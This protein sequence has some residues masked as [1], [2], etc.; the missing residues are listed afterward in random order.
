VDTSNLF[1]DPSEPT[2]VT[3]AISTAAERSFLTYRGANVRFP[4]LVRS[5]A[6]E[7]RH[8]HLACPADLE[9][10]RSFGCPVSVDA[11]WNENWLDGAMELL[12]SID[13]FFPNHAEAKR[14][15]GESNWRK[16]LEAFAEAGARRVAL[17]LGYAGAA[18]L[19]DGDMM[20]VEPISVEVV[21]T[22][23]AGDCF[24]AGFLHFWLHGA[25]PMECLRAANICGAR[26]TEAM[27][28]VN[29]FPSLERV[30]QELCAR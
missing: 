17:K 24:D 7:A 27:G 14:M 12:P 15:T 26:S 18:L 4:D 23:G 9:S 6:T 10:I 8:V 5:F 3:V 30:R 25:S 1:V 19:W 2:A 16:I 29:G 20:R 28:G 22:T 21:D 11:G 13:L